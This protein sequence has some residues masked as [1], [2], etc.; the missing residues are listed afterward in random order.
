MKKLNIS[1]FGCGWLGLP[2]LKSLVA[3]GHRVKGSSRSPE[4]LLAITEAGGKAF[5]IDLPEEI[6]TAFFD[7]VDLLIVTLPPGGRRLGSAKAMERYSTVLAPIV[8]W[9]AAQSIPPRLIFTSS[10]GVYGDASGLVT[11]T[12]PLDLFSSPSALA[13]TVA[14]TQLSLAYPTNT[15]LRLSGLVAA[16]RHPG[17]FYGGRERLVP[18]ADAPVNLVHRKDVIAAI[19]LL[20]EKNTPDVYNVCAQ[21]HPTKGAFYTAAARSLGL[22]IKG[23]EPGGKESKIISSQKLRSLGWQPSW[24]NL[25][26]KALKIS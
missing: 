6:P 5:H 13:L 8:A 7:G 20:L 26:L 21:A 2:L 14:E 9:G 10:T 24:D 22:E 4:T 11:E 15:I 19:H 17:R 16:D 18:E 25:D 23:I 3:D 12:A 1:I